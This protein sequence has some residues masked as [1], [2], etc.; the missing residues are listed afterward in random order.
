MLPG[1]KA[2]LQAAGVHLILCLLVAMVTATVV[3]GLWYPYPYRESSSGRELF[4][5][6]ISVDAALGPVVTFTVFNRNKP[7]ATLARDLAIVGVLQ[8]AAL[9]CGL[10]AVYFARP[11][12]LVFESDR[13]SVVH[14]IEIPEELLMQAP[15]EYRDMPMTGPTMLSLRPWRDNAE[16]AQATMLA[17]QG[18]PLNARADLW[19]SYDLARPDVLAQA[20][21]MA[22]LRTKFPH[23]Q[24]EIDA[25]VQESGLPEQELR[26]LPMVERKSFW[27]VLIDAKNAEI[28]GYIPLDPF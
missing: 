4:L 23:R 27:T 19:Q 26:Y 14:A 6:L 15:A 21:S 18:F 11:V 2:R 24:A 13:F 20:K 22:L 17:L 3:F 5:I 1:W 12:H 8:L 28:R 7:R 9:G 25:A 16:K 10:W